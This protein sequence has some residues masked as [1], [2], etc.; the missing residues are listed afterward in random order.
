VLKKEGIPIVILRRAT[1]R[2][3]RSLS[4]RQT[5]F[6]KRQTAFPPPPALSK[7]EGAGEG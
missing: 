6:S 3:R 7:V 5:L 1:A 2:V 4:K